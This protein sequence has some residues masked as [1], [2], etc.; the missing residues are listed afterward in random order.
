MFVMEFHNKLSQKWNLFKWRKAEHML[1]YTRA[2]THTN[3]VDSDQGEHKLRQNIYCPSVCYVCKNSV[4]IHIHAVDVQNAHMR[5]GS[6]KRKCT[7]KLKIGLAKRKVPIEPLNSM[8]L[9]WFI[10]FNLKGMCFNLNRKS[11][12]FRIKCD[13]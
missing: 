4:F 7:F 3:I 6:W 11:N 8:I 13:V 12:S 5:S 9:I 1:V 2:H 10:V